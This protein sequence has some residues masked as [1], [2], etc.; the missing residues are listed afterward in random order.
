MTQLFSVFDSA[1]ARF[2]EPW[3]AQTVELALRRFRHTVNKEGN[4]ISMFPEDYTLFHVG[5]FDQETGRVTAFAAPHSLG[6]AIT[7]KERP[8]VMHPDA[9]RLSEVPD[10]DG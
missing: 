6:V 9:V 8:Q 1:A 4:D 2:T 7:F 5:E 3:P 10:A